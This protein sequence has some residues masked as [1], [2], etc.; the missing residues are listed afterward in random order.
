MD[1]EGQSIGSSHESFSCRNRKDP[2]LLSH[3]DVLSKSGG[4]HRRRAIKNED[5]T[6][7][8]KK[9]ERVLNRL[10]VSAPAPHHE[11]IM[12]YIGYHH[13]KPR[14]DLR[15]KLS[16]YDDSEQKIRVWNSFVDSDLTD[17]TDDDFS[18]LPRVLPASYWPTLRKT[19]FHITTFA[20]RL[21]SL[22]EKEVRAIVPPGPIRDH[23]LD[24]LEIL[25][26]RNGRITGSF[27]FDMAVV[28]APDKNHPPQLLEINEIGF[29]GLSRSS[30]FQRALLDLLP[31]LRG[32]L[33]SLDTA[34]AEI[35]NMNRLGP[36]IA[37]LQNDCYNWDEEY[38]L[39]TAKRL[40]SDVRLITPA[41]FG[42]KIDADFPLLEKHPI[43]FRQN[44]A[45]VGGW[46]PDAFNMSFAYTLKDYRKGHDL[47]RRLVRSQTPQ[48]GPFLTGLVAAKTVLVLLADSALRKRLLGSSKLLADSV[49]PAHLLDDA[50]AAFSP[51]QPRDWVLKYTDGFGGEQ[52]YM[53]NDLLRQLRKIPPRKRHEWVLQKKTQLNLIDVNGILSRPKRAISD[54]G[55]FVQYDWQNGRFRH[56]EIGGLMCRATNKNLKVNVSSGGLQVAVLLDRAT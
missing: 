16:K 40:K 10:D 46:R 43:Q 41:Q 32:R 2:I 49:L 15:Q 24:E 27:R 9:T 30:F 51:E 33:K 29:D 17:V 31:N 3:P 35:R 26:F 38:L 6:K 50:R 42:F 13:E 48:Y 21:L 1:R 8:E 25:R 20:M 14:T 12:K 11:K 18:I 19:A 5:Q 4:L 53:D 28:G 52:V 22:P 23:L 39:R 34:A 7:A 36:R 37:R 54:L 44:R 47:Y 55:V 56:F 45:F